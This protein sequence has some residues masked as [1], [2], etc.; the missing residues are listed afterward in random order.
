MEYL[1]IPWQI[2]LLI[3]VGFALVIVPVLFTLVNRKV[4]HLYVSVCYCVA[5]LL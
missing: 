4:E 2:G 3:F 5:G 1:E